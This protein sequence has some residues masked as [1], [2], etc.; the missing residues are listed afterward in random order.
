MPFHLNECM[1][2]LGNQMFSLATVYSLAKQYNTTFSIDTSINEAKGFVTNRVYY[3]VFAKVLNSPLCAPM[4][5]SLPTVVINMKQFENYICKDTTASSHTFVV[6]GLPMFFPLLESHIDAFA[7]EFHKSL[8]DH[9][10]QPIVSCQ[11]PTRICIGMRTF[12][13]ENQPQWSTSLAYY[14]RAI[15]SISKQYDSVSIHVYTDKEGSSEQIIPYIQTHFGPKCV[16]I[17]EYCGSKEKKTDVTHFFQMF[18]YDHYILCI[19]TYHYWPAMLSTNTDKAVI[20]PEE[21]G[22]YKHI[23][24]PKWIAL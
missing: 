11:T 10:P 19:S 12:W 23:A 4:N 5:S 24:H 15:E 20:Y 9:S 17:E 6:T 8:E 1:G 3:D 14:N 13:N 22:W 21:V 7:K 16:S 2:G 18:H